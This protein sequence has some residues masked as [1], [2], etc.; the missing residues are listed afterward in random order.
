MYFKLSELEKAEKAYTEDL[1][2]N[3]KPSMSLKS[4]SISSE[5]NL[6]GYTVEEAR[7]VLDKYLDDCALANLRS[8]RIIHGKGT[9]I[10]RM[11]IHDFLKSNPH[12]ENYRMRFFWR[13]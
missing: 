9:G 2:V 10:L 4:S 8:I 11:G 5:I 12:V 1:V 6:L 3:H 13:R 7:L